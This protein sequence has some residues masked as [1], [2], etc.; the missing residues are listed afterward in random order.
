MGERRKLVTD[1][2]HQEKPT[3]VTLDKEAGKLSWSLWVSGE[4]S[5]SRTPNLLIKSQLLC[6]LS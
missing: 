4:P 1:G 3:L 2:G 6:Q 5:G